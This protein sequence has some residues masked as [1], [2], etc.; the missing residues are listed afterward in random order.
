MFYVHEYTIGSM[1]ERWKYGGVRHVEG[2]VQRRVFIGKFNTPKKT[3]TDDFS[4]NLLHIEL[5]NKYQFY[6]NIKIVRLF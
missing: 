2:I 1:K 6:E 5:E 3:K 4:H